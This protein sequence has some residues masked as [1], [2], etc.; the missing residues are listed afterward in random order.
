MAR[1]LAPY[2]RRLAAVPPTLLL[3]ALATFALARLA[4]GGP[5]VAERG[6]DPATLAALDRLYGLDRPW[7]EQFAR[8]LWAALHFD[9]GPSLTWRDS[10]VSSLIAAAWP[11]SFELGAAALALAFL[12][13]APLGAWAA[14]RRGSSGDA[15]AMGAAGMLQ[16]TPSFALAP[17]VQ[18]SLGLWLR[19]LPVGG[20]NGGDLR[21]L[22][23]PALVLAAPQVAA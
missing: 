3:V 16:A 15:V 14:L 6:I 12:V 21:H 9:F 13:G 20:W 2:A 8:W 11:T 19:A 22:A 7:P 1:S 17:L 10:S 18:L 5:F 23:L 4:P